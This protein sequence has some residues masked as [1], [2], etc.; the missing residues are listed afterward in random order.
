MTDQSQRRHGQNNTANSAKRHKL[1]QELLKQISNN[2]HEMI[3][4]SQDA[5]IARVKEF[6]VLWEKYKSLFETSANYTASGLD[7]FTATKLIADLGAIGARVR[8]K[9]Y[10]GKQHI[11]IK[12]RIGLRKTLTAARYSV[13][14]PK[15]IK[16]GLGTSAAINAVKQ[17]GLLTIY[18]ITAFR[19]ADYLLTDKATL[20]SLIGPLATDIV[21]VGIAC[22]A[23]IVAASI[24]GITSAATLAIGPLVAV[25]IVGV[26]AS[27]GLSAVDNHFGITEQLV[28]VLEIRHNRPRITLPHTPHSHVSDLGY[29]SITGGFTMGQAFGL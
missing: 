2:Q 22:G 28:K 7:T 8:V 18:L 12:G 20:S 16:M 1:Q 23:S 29:A 25:I 5:L 11:I 3:V 19:V 24:L 13:T 21:K 6:P 10:A 4:L 14:N 15:V 17:G 27:A 26:I 9:T